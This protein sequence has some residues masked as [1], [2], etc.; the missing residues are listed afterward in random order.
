MACLL[1]GWVGVGLA[2]RVGSGPGA[3]YYV[4]SPACPL[5]GGLVVARLGA[6]AAEA[7]S[8]PLWLSGGSFTCPLMEGFVVPPNYFC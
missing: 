7:F 2:H 5:L 3:T 1:P 8:L 4:S 6:V